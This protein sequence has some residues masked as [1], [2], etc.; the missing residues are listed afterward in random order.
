MSL[1]LEPLQDMAAELDVCI[2][3]VHHTGK[4]NVDNAQAVDIFDTIRGSSAIRAVCRG[5][6]VIAASERDYRLVVEN[7]WGKHD[8]KVVLDANTLTWR[9]L[10]RWNPVSNA[11]QKDQILDFLRQTQQATIEQISDAT[12]IDKKSLYTQL[13]RLQISELAE[14][15][16]VKEGKRRNYT[17]RL[18]L[19]N[20]IQQ[21]NSVLNSANSDQESDRG[22][23]QQNIICDT[24]DVENETEISNE[25]SKDCRIVEYSAETQTEQGFCL[26]NSYSTVEYSPGD[27]VEIRKSGMFYGKH[28]K[29]EAIEGDAAVVKGQTWLVTQTHR[30]SDLRKLRPD[31][32]P[33]QR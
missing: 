33:S 29:I 2:V 13:S 7:G 8:L 1:V 20:N 14:E 28:A 23:I 21:L 25:D 19:F 32:L 16:I 12:G 26:F 22:D 3:L 6:M 27:W 24:P 4:V 15:K 31:E 9:L 5:S 18:A 17:Y 11:T 10:G 30:L